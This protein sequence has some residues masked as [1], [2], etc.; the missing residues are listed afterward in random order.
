MNKLTVVQDFFFGN[1]C[2]VNDKAD[3]N[4]NDVVEVAKDVSA[5]YF[6]GQLNRVLA[7][8]GGELVLSN[9]T[10]CTDLT[11]LFDKIL[12]SSIGKIEI[13]RHTDVNPAVDCTLGCNIYLDEGV[14]QVKAHWCARNE[15]RAG[16]IFTSLISPLHENEL[17]EVTFVNNDGQLSPLNAG[18]VNFEFEIEQI[19]KLA[20]AE[21]LNEESFV[22]RMTD[23]LSN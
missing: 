16:Q 19:L 10:S 3:L 8:V 21:S 4:L 18:G 22:T 13:V 23:I 11:P 17:F 20:M 9:S 14:I 12:S 6:T 5:S 7:K 2:V 1:I 15:D